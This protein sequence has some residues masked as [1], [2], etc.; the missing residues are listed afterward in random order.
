M[1]KGFFFDQSRCIGCLTCSVAC[2]EWHEYELGCEP[3]DWIRVSSHETGKYPAISLT[4]LAQPCYHC[5]HAPCITACPVDAIT[6]HEDGIVTVDRGIC[7]GKS[8][9]LCLEA[10]PYDTPQFGSDENALMQK[11]D[12]CIGRW[13]EG[14]KP[15]CVEAC[16]TRALDAGPIEELRSMY[17]DIR[18][19]EGFTYSTADPCVTFKLKKVPKSALSVPGN[20]KKRENTKQK[21]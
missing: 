6:K 1:N 19:A 11:C 15:I 14:K 5:L 3:E 16:P 2:K 4:Y 8:C 10:C 12:L 20:E 13:A 7:L 17:G 21:K 18:T 9:G